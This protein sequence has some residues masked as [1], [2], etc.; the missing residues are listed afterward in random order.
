M[1]SPAPAVKSANLQGGDTEN[2]AVSSGGHCHSLSTAKKLADP[3]GTCL[4]QLQTQFKI[5]GSAI[6]HRLALCWDHVLLR[7]ARE[8]KEQKVRD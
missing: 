2:P 5:L 6:S 7:G 8:S 1:V 4:A 3:K